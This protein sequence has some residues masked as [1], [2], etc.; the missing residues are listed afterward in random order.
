MNT[1]FLDKLNQIIKD[2]FT[3]DNI[4]GYLD[5]NAKLYHLPYYNIALVYNQFPSAKYLAGQYVWNNI[6]NKEIIED[7][8]PILCL[9]PK[10]TSSNTLEF[11]IGTLFDISQMEDSDND[12]ELFIDIEEVIKSKGFIVYPSDKNTNSIES[13]GLDITEKAIYIDK[14]LEGNKYLETLIKA[15]IDYKFKTSKG[16][17][18]YAKEK[19]QMVNY[20]VL[21]AFDMDLQYAKFLFINKLVK[22]FTIDDIC[23]FLDDIQLMVLEIMKDFVG[24]FISFEEINFLNQ[25]LT[26]NKEDL[27]DLS[28]AEDESFHSKLLYGRLNDIRDLVDKIEDYDQ[29]LADKNEYKLVS[30][31]YYYINKRT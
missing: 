20:V 27:D 6:L 29:L 9:Y 18:Q 1:Q 14:S 7:A 24:E 25:L 19:R 5:I 3:M 26:S 17:I 2:L 12:F 22:S 10:K 8:K 15:Y 31:P 16:V 13:Y 4:N 11:E 21:K 30:F 23:D 28:A